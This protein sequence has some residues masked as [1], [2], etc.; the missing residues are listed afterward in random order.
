MK[1]KEKKKEKE[2]NDH[3]F[4]NR[5]SEEHC[6]E[7]K[8]RCNFPCVVHQSRDEHRSSITIVQRLAAEAY[9][10]EIYI[11]RISFVRI[12]YKNARARVIERE[13]GACLSR[14]EI[15]RVLYA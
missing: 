10:L 4:S 5:G 11:D 15:K 7:R 2:S 6:A 9:R 13:R 14:E 12:E 8:G 3:V 1:E